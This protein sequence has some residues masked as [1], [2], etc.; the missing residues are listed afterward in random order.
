VTKYV[1]TRTADC[2][3]WGMME[4]EGVTADSYRAADGTSMRAVLFFEAPSWELA[5]QVFD[6]VSKRLRQGLQ[7]PLRGKQGPSSWD[8]VKALLG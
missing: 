6:L 3:E 1:I 2:A 4:L 5:R 7:R 8:E